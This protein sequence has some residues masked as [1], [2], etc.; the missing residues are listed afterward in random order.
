M[1]IIENYVYVKK[2]NIDLFEMKLAVDAMYDFIK[3]SF[4]PGKDDYSGQSTMTTQLYTQYNLLMY[5][6]A[7]FHELYLGIRDTFHSMNKLNTSHNFLQCWLN[8]YR[9]GEFIDWHYHWPPE[10]KSWHGFYCVDCE[11]SHTTYRIPGTNKEVDIESKNNNLV[12]SKSNG[13]MHRSWPWPY[14]DRPRITVAFDIV[15]A[16]SLTINQKFGSINHWV[17]I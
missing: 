10:N 2:L 14:S 4:V 12:L 17:P 16:D 7:P 8:Y 11:P 13:D 9:E 1:E 15:P 3:D 5:P 6:Y